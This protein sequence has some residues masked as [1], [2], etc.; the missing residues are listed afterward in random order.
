[1][2]LPSVAK[3]SQRVVTARA[4][5]RAGHAGHRLTLATVVM[6]LA[7]PAWPAAMQDP[8]AAAILVQVADESG[9]AVGGQEVYVVVVLA[10]ALNCTNADAVRRVAAGESEE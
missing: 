10:Q 4:R 1:M 9:S 6:A 2:I 5:L 3:T 7:A 8:G